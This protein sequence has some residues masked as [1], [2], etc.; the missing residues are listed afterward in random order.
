M[1]HLVN[2]FTKAMGY[3]A[4]V[5]SY[6]AGWPSAIFHTFMDFIGSVELTKWLFSVGVH[7]VADEFYIH[8]VEM[9]MVV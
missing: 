6:R 7:V 2:P 3:A 1:Q 4:Y 9:F 5:G 8:F